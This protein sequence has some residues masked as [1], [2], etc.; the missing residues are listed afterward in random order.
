MKRA[1]ALLTLLPLCLLA[2][3]GGDEEV[4]EYAGKP[5]VVT[6]VETRD[7]EERIEASG[8]LIAKQRADVA[9]Q[10][11][12][13]ITEVLAEEGAAVEEGAV[14]MEI[15]P[16]RRNLELD[17]TRA[18]VG[19]AVASV[20]EQQREVKRM[21]VLAKQSVASATK[22]DKTE[23]ALATARSRLAAANADKGVAERAL[24]DATVQARFAGRIARRYVDRGEFVREGQVLFDLVTLDPV[25]VEFHLPEAD[26]SRV[27]TGTPI[28][29]TVAS[30]PDEVF[31]ATVNVVSPVIDP[32]TRTLRVRA[33]IPNEDGRL[34][35]GFFARANLGV[36]L[37]EDVLMVPEEAVLRRA[38]GDVVFR[39][40]GN[41][42][43]RIVVETGTI[44]DG[45]VEI[46]QGLR[47]GDAVV[48][49]GHADLIDGSVVVSRNP[50]GTLA[51]EAA[52]VA[53][54]GETDA[55]AGVAAQ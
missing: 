11:S 12:G 44:R 33:L 41:R 21:R 18:R 31:D 50:D 13:E 22:L 19:E 51:G 20:R 49:R 43:E 27:Q 16:E 45:A 28:E 10:V 32:R 40:D 38:D 17:R 26:A 30:Y 9:A 37:R 15:D 6:P 34:R 55:A 2:A 1:V 24:R 42:V 8:Q 25:E 54:P 46:R 4:A 35:P 52:A 5:V 48:A 7:L 53:A 47:S 14:V 29:V 36:A 39:V 3:C 23:T